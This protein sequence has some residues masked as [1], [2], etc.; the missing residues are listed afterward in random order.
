MHVR[1]CPLSGVKRT[2]L[3]ALQMSADDPKRTFGV[4]NIGLQSNSISSATAGIL[5][6]DTQAHRLRRAAAAMEE[7]REQTCGN[8]TRFILC[9]IG[10]TCAEYFFAGPPEPKH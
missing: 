3:F 5:A 7:V 2:S 9:S 1:T 10:S 6:A 4:G 8:S